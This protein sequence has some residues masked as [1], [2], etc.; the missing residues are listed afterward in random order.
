[1]TSGEF[2]EVLVVSAVPSPAQ[3]IHLADTTSRGRMGLGSVQFHTFRTNATEQVHARHN[4]AADGWFLDGHVEGLQR[5]R[6]EPLGITE[7]FGADTIP[8]YLP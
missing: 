1:M 3:Y 2:G 5:T 7:L 6:L 4:R 8:G